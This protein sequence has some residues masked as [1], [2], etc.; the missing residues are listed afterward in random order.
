MSWWGYAE[1]FAQRPMPFSPKRFAIRHP[2]LSFAAG[3][4]LAFAV[5][6]WL[7]PKP[8]GLHITFFN[9][10]RE[11]LQTLELDFGHASGQSKLLALSIAPG[12]SRALW[13][14]HVPGA[15]FNV[16][17]TWAG[18]KHIEFCALKGKPQRSANVRLS[19]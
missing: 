3:A 7:L 19:P 2:Y 16:K 6:T 15:G 1:H 5:Q 13:L 8:D 4:L 18:G 17:A 14:N 10:G 12:S 9:D 11:T